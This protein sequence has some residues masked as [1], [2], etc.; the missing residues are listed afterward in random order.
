MDEQQLPAQPAPQVEQPVSTTAPSP[1]VSPKRNFLPLLLAILV[2]A[3]VFGAGGYF[4]GKT[5][6]TSIIPSPTPSPVIET[7][8]PSPT[9]NPTP[10]DSPNTATPNGQGAEAT[11]VCENKYLGLGVT[12]LPE[13]WTCE[14]K[15]LNAESGDGYIKLDA[16]GY[17]IMI[18]NLGIDSLGCNPDITPGCTSEPFFSN[19]VLTAK[20]YRISGEEKGIFGSTSQKA[21]GTSGQTSQSVT[22]ISADKVPTSS[23]DFTGAETAAIKEI[24]KR[25]TV[26]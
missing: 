2:S 3:V 23:R 20:L 17:A 4:I 6:P 13:G 21:V 24:F 8:T 1:V 5:M 15:T 18:S 14:S 10:T 16:P 25:I 19:D 7:P 11:T 26:L 12:K 9:V 22:W